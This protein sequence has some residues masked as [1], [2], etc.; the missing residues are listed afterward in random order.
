LAHGNKKK[1]AKLRKRRRRRSARLLRKRHDEKLL[2]RKQTSGRLNKN[3]NKNRNPRE[4]Q[5][6]RKKSYG[7]PHHFCRLFWCPRLM[8]MTCLTDGNCRRKLENPM[9]SLPLIKQLNINTLITP[10]NPFL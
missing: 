7:S 6:K 10:L 1:Y 4:R 9:T 2:K 8:M 5:K 3:K